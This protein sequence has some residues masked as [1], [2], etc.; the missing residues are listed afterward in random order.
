MR[1]WEIIF[2]EKNKIMGNAIFEKILV[3]AMLSHAEEKEKEREML[4]EKNWEAI[5]S[6]SQDFTEGR[7]S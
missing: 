6:C 2:T 1:V 3:M 4:T 5:K 7:Q